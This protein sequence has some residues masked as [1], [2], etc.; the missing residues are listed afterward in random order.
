MQTFLFAPLSPTL[1][2]LRSA[3]PRPGSLATHGPRQLRF[4]SSLSN[5]QTAA[6][7]GSDAVNSF[8]F[9]QLRSAFLFHIVRRS[10]SVKAWC[11][12]GP[13]GKKFR[14]PSGKRL[15]PAKFSS[16]IARLWK[17]MEDFSTSAPRLNRD[18][19]LHPLRLQCFRSG[20]I[21]S[22]KKLALR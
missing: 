5:A 13:G 15:P 9:Y 4:R 8:R 14:R 17:R 10:S 6:L 12:P 16:T 20:Y 21:P 11:M 22:I 3:D 1:Q 2:R 19:Q 7:V 18:R